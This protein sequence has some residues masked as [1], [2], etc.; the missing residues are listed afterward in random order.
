MIRSTATISRASFIIH[1][2]CLRT[3]RSFFALHDNCRAEVKA[4]WKESDR[5]LVTNGVRQG[6][7]SKPAL[8]SLHYDVA[9][10]MAMDENGSRGMGIKVAYLHDT[11]LV[12]NRTTLRFESLENDL[13][14][15]MHGS[16]L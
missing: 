1:I 2:S 3:F 5:F 4:Y 12:A 13:E 6:C 14:Y 9:I 8:F 7:V 15:D 11:D 16:S 10:H